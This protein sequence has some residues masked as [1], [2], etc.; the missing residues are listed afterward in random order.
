MELVKLKSSFGVI[1]FPSNLVLSGTAAAGK[2]KFYV[3][4]AIGL[5]SQFGVID[6]NSQE[7]DVNGLVTIQAIKESLKTHAFIVVRTK[8]SSNVASQLDNAVKIVRVG[9]KEEVIPTTF[10]TAAY[11][12]EDANN[13]KLVTMDTPFVWDNQAGISIVTAPTNTV[14]TVFSIVAMVPYGNLE[15]FLMDNNIPVGADCKC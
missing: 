3:D 13:D 12:S 14:T 11:L 10:E 9:L 8:Y 1:G 2:T 7:L 15:K 6:G 4:P 5:F